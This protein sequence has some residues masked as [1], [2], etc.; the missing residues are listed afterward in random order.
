MIYLY[1]ALGKEKKE[2]ERQ[3]LKPDKNKHQISPM[4]YMFA[5]CSDVCDLQCPPKMC[6]LQPPNMR[7]LGIQDYS[8][9]LISRISL[10]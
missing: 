3:K 7:S 8:L 9:F 10:L 2:T 1:F 6:S 5:S 4:L